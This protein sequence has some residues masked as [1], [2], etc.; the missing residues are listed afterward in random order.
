MQVGKVDI[1]PS[2]LPKAARQSLGIGP[3]FKSKFKWNLAHVKKKIG[4]G[5]ARALKSVGSDIRK[6]SQRMMSNRKPKKAKNWRI[7][8]RNGF[9]LVAKV[10]RVPKSDVVTSWKT[11]KHP[12]GFLLSDIEYDYSPR[13]QSVVVGPSKAPTINKLQ[14]FGGQTKVYFKPYPRVGPARRTRRIYGRLTNKP[15][16]AGRGIFG[17]PEAGIYSFTAKLKPRR[18]ME[19]GLD[20]ALPGIPLRFRNQI[21]GP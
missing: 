19:K 21:R 18:F 6:A 3:S 5:N 17:V 14:E 15:P 11:S 4:E 10:D 1:D 12:K 13:T 20:K 7:A 16:Q 8:S 9:E 2:F